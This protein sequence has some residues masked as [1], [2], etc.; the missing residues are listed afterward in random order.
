[1]AISVKNI[2][3]VALGLALVFIIT[4]SILLPQF[5]SAW[6]YC[7][8]RQWVATQ[9]GVMTNCTTPYQTANTTFVDTTGTSHTEG[10]LASPLNSDTGVGVDRFC[11]N[12]STAGGY[13]TTVQGVLLLVLVLFLVA[14]GLRYFGR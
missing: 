12:C 6:R 1:M 3:A 11:L 7:Q 8:A 9:G 4:S 2:T 14:I 5:S 13:R 10:G